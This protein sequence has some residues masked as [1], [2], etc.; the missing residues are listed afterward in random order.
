ML[1]SS[2]SLG[3]A[4][5]PTVCLSSAAPVPGAFVL[6]VVGTSL[7]P[8]LSNI[9]YYNLSAPTLSVLATKILLRLVRPIELHGGCQFPIQTLGMSTIRTC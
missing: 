5:L 9:Q 4:L 3:A 8:V 2:Y 6:F 1:A 7:L